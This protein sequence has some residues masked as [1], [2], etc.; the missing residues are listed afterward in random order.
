MSSGVS[1]LVLWAS[2]VGAALRASVVGAAH[3]AMAPKKT[4]TVAGLQRRGAE[5]VNLGLC[6]DQLPADWSAKEALH[7]PEVWLSE[8]ASL[9][10]L[11]RLAIQ[12]D[13]PACKFLPSLKG[14]DFEKQRQLPAEIGKNAAATRADGAV[15][16]ARASLAQQG[17]KLL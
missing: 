1:A 10:A 5:W 2:V 14:R 8:H 15:K 9:H 3:S 16:S 4:K 11:R 6:F 12:A 13:Q 17:T 7:N